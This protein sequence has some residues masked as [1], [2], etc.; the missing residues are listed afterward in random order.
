MD[1]KIPNNSM[2]C[3]DGTNSAKNLGNETCCTSY[4][5]TSSKYKS[6]NNSDYDNYIVDSCG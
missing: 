6:L 3:P 1:V 5:Q 2:S 4:E